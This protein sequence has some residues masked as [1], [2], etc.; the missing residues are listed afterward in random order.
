[1]N[2][3]KVCLKFDFCSEQPLQDL[4]KATD[5]FEDSTNPKYKHKYAINPEGVANKRW[6]CTIYS[7]NGNFSRNYVLNQSKAFASELVKDLFL[8]GYQELV[9]RSEVIE[10]FEIFSPFHVFLNGCVHRR[11][12]GFVNKTCC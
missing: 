8:H 3:T 10:A 4:L 6:W 9:Y 11:T 2:E 5:T 7:E 12:S 1:M